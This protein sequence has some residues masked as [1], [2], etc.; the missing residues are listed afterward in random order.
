MRAVF[1]DAPARWA[2]RA[3]RAWFRGKA[4]V[5][6]RAASDLVIRGGDELGRRNRRRI[7][8]PAYAL[9]N[10]RAAGIVIVRRPRGA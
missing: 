1:L 3:R 6:W 4:R 7:R 10:V 5:G 2:G 9:P 8:D